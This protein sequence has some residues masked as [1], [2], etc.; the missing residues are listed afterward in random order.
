MFWNKSSRATLWWEQNREDWLF[1]LN[2]ALI[3]QL[4]CDRLVIKLNIDLLNVRYCVVRTTL[5][6][7]CS[8]EFNFETQ[9]LD[10]DGAWETSKLERRSRTRAHGCARTHKRFSLETKSSIIRIV[11]SKPFETKYPKLKK[12][13]DLNASTCDILSHI[14][15]AR[16]SILIHVTQLTNAYSFSEK[17]E[18]TELSRTRRGWIKK[19]GL[20]MWTWFVWLVMESSKDRNQTADDIWLVRAVNFPVAEWRG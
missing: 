13:S 11:P 9:L 2:V 8:F 3:G 20:R 7:F 16:I 18:E 19:W 12:N 6:C 10:L 4:P 14:F 1:L 5:P 17:P 15:Y